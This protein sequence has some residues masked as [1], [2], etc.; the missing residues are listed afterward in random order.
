MNKGP[1][2]ASAQPSR[3]DLAKLFTLDADNGVAREL[4]QANKRVEEG[5]RSSQP[6]NR[7]QHRL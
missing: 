6:P 5:D 4:L 7:G 2:T 3:I 1:L